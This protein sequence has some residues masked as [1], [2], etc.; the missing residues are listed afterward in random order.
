MLEDVS[1]V[2]IDGVQPTRSYKCSEHP[3][4]RP[5]RSTVRQVRLNVSQSTVGSSGTLR[6]QTSGTGESLS[7]CGSDDV[8]DVVTGLR[9]V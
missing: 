1:T 6:D 9:S 2:H 3:V 8:D 4:F 5:D 7:K